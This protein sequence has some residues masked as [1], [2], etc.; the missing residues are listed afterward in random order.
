MNL[1]RKNWQ[2]TCFNIG[3][4]VLILIALTVLV[5][6]GKPEVT[7]VVKPAEAEQYSYELKNR[8]CTTGEQSFSTLAKTC[9]GLM[10]DKLNNDCARDEREELFESHDCVTIFSS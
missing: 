1:H 8:S 7:Y 6:C 5:S 4:R 3:M 2:I 10:D 9:E